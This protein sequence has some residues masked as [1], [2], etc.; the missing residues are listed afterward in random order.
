M[1]KPN[2]NSLQSLVLYNFYLFILFVHTGHVIF[3]FNAIWETLIR[4]LFF[5]KLLLG[6]SLSS[7]FKDSFIN[8]MLI[9][10]S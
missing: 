1:L 6:S 10:T 7:F 4:Y 3:N 5:S 2:K 8:P 9:A